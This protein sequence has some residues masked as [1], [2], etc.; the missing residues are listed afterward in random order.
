M[1]DF[2]Y[3]LNKLIVVSDKITDNDCLVPLRNNIAM[4]L[5]S[6]KDPLLLDMEVNHPQNVRTIIKEM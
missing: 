4:K 5:L 6:M 1:T 2:Q 3:N